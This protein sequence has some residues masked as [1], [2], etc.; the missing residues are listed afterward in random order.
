MYNDLF[1]AG[2]YIPPLDSTSTISSFKNN[3]AYNLIQEEITNFSQKGS[4]ALCG[5]FNPRTG[6]L[7]DFLATP[8]NDNLSSINGLGSSDELPKLSRYTEDN[9]SNKYGR[10]LIELCKSSNVRIMNGYCQNDRSYL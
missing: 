6:S 2:I 9:K 3:N 1:I 4:V 8:G 5:D 10:E 7:S